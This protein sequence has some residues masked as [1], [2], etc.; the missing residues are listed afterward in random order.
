[1]V[2][3]KKMENMYLSLQEK[4]A[5]HLEISMTILK[6]LQIR[7]LLNLIFIT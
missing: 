2:E 1:M 5:C 4:K 7:K 3:V 6:E